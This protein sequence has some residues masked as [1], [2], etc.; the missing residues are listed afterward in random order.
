MAMYAVL[1]IVLSVI[2]FALAEFSWAYLV[3]A[4]VLDV[5]LAIR[6]ARLF[7]V[8]QRGTAIDRQTALP[9]Y[10]FSM[11]YLALLFLAMAL[12]RAFFA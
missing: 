8:A 7:V 5:L 12:D 1:T 4:L 9:V 3:A 6:V 2:P 11:L 10:K